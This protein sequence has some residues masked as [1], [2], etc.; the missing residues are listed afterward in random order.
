MLKKKA[1]Q[2]ANQ[3]RRYNKQYRKREAPRQHLLQQ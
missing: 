1:R 2:N 3:R